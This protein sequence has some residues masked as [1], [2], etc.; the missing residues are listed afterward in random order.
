M[1][2]QMKKYMKIVVLQK[3]EKN[4]LLLEKVE[5]NVKL[6]ESTLMTKACHHKT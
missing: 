3:G 5:F 1:H 2:N 6:G 4:V